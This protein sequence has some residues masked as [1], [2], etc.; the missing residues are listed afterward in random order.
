MEEAIFKRAHWEFLVQLNISKLM[1]PPLVSAEDKSE[2]SHTSGPSPTG[3]GQTVA[4]VPSLPPCHCLAY[5]KYGHHFLSISYAYPL[6]GVMEEGQG[7]GP[8]P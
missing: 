7:S 6:L 4:P 1:S 8:L 3:S 5:L 2:H